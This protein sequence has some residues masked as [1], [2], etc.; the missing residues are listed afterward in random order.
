ME[1]RTFL[2]KSGGAILLMASSATT[3]Y[4]G[5][6]KKLRFGLVAD[7]HFAR[8]ET[9]WARYYGQSKAKLNDA[10]NIF[11]KSNLEFVLELGDFKDEGN[12]PGREETIEF[13]V[14]IEDVLSRFRGPVYHVLGNHDMDSISKDDFLQNIKNH[15][16]ARAKSYYSFTD[17]GLKFIVLDANFNEDGSDYN[18]GNFDWT[19][20]RIP[21]AQKE[22]LQNE[23]NDD[24]P[25]IVFTHQLLDSFSGVSETHCIDNAPEVVE[26]LE[27]NN[28]VLAVFQGHYH[29]G[30][31]SFRKGIHYYTMK[32]MVEGSLPDNNSYAIAEVDN[33][34]NIIVEGFYNCEDYIMKYPGNIK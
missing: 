15:G 3:S 24:L 30:N 31:Y 29:H 20:S 22:W 9:M 26:I 4:A 8:R 11:N 23:L 16:Q 2:K 6:S 7:A 25:V 28:N 10:V 17:N 18:S 12:P 33:D 21:D 5:L 1:R 13:L 14:E 32:A 27:K 34:L 19:Y